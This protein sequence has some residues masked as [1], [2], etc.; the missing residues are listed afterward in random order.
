MQKKPVSASRTV[1]W[2]MREII[3]ITFGRGVLWRT[4]EA[5]GIGMENR[6]GVC[7]FSRFRGICMRSHIIW[8]ARQVVPV[9]TDG[10]LLV[11]YG[12]RQV[13]PGS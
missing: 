8:S 11:I 1:V 7:A 2:M 12:N 9:P 4:G 10:I 13:V 3:N 5:G 6:F